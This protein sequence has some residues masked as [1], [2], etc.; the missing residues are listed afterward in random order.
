MGASRSIRLARHSEEVYATQSL[1]FQHGSFAARAVAVISKPT[2]ILRRTNH[3]K[4]LSKNSFARVGPQ[5]RS[6]EGLASAIAVAQ[7][8]VAVEVGPYNELTI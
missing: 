8:V 3:Q 2:R 1:G 6:K 4:T 7:P 5:I